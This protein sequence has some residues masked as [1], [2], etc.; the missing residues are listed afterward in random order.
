MAGTDLLLQT[1]SPEVV[2]DE[3]RVIAAD[4]H[5]VEANDVRMIDRLADLELMLQDVLLFGFTKRFWQQ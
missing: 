4:V 5:L 2:H 3:V 1:W